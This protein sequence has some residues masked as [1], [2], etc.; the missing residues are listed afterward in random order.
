M[1]FNQSA[2]VR[3]VF[4]SYNEPGRSRLELLRTLV[5]VSVKEI[6][7]NLKLEESLKWG[8]PTYAVKGGSPFRLGWSKKAPEG[9]AV[10]FHCQTSLIETI[11]A[12][13][14]DQ[15]IYEGKRAIVFP[16][17]VKI[18]KKIVSHC[19]ELALTYHKIK[20]LPHLGALG[21]ST[22]TLKSAH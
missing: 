8:Q 6:N 13:Y 9:C 3:A 20:H 17:N 19:L 22:S 16:A 12:I 15:L 4:E 14:G 10:F 7:P 1:E 11:K 2:D 18:P 21:V 5:L